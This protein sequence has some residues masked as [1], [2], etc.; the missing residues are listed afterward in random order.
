[1]WW[2]FILKGAKKRKGRKE[3]WRGERRDEEGRRLDGRRKKTV[4]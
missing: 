3:E 4:L 1:M 2:K